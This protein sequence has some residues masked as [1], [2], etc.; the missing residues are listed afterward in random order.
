M[1]NLLLA[2]DPSVEWNNARVENL[3]RS[4][5]PRY[6]E[7]DIL[8]SVRCRRSRSSGSPFATTVARQLSSRAKHAP[9][10]L[11]GPALMRGW[12]VEGRISRQGIVENAESRS[13]GQK[14][15]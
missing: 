15:L 10:R 12:A 13:L 7:T 2:F 3:L 4:M 9:G 6:V 1:I 5:W 11:Q 8:S 14:Q